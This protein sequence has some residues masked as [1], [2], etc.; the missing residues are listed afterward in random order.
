V[1]SHEALLRIIGDVASQWTR[2]SRGRLR[3][4][5]DVTEE[6][7]PESQEVETGMIT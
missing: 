2:D 7:E 4:R 5:Q 1:A 6:E 3:R